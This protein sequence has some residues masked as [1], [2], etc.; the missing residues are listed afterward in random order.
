MLTLKGNV[1]EILESVPIAKLCINESYTQKRVK[2]LVKLVKLFL[3]ET[4]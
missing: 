3:Y 4:K 2:L 1:A